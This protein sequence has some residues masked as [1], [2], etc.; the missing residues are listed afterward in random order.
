[1]PF[2]ECADLSISQVGAWGHLTENYRSIAWGYLSRSAGWC[3]IRI[4]RKLRSAVKILMLF[5]CGQNNGR[6]LQRVTWNGY[7]CPHI[8]GGYV[9][10]DSVLAVRACARRSCRVELLPECAVQR[11]QWKR[12]PPH[13][14]SAMLL[15]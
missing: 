4:R 1:M 11:R 13:G 9:V 3:A 7:T 2:H 10:N 15:K 8:Q 5:T 14:S 6:E 12:L